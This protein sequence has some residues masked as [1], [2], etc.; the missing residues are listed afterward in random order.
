MAR[1]NNQHPTIVGWVP[2]YI[3]QQNREVDSIKPS[4]EERAAS[5]EQLLAWPAGVVK[6]RMSQF[7]SIPYSG[8]PS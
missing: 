2:A 5:A 1:S 4:Y 6:F 7:M 8:S 3:S